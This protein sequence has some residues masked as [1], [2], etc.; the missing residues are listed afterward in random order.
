MKECVRSWSAVAW[1]LFA[2]PFIFLIHNPHVGTLIN[3]LVFEGNSCS[4]LLCVFVWI[5]N[6]VGN[7][8]HED[9][10]GGRELF[11]FQCLRSANRVQSIIVSLL[12]QFYSLSNVVLRFL[13]WFVFSNLH[14][15]IFSFLYLHS[16]SYISHSK[17]H[18]LTLLHLSCI[19]FLVS[20]YH[21]YF[22]FLN[23]FLTFLYLILWRKSHDSRIGNYFCYPFCRFRKL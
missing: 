23:F 3:K 4:V 13:Q 1:H 22:L 19:S 20:F 14:F 7:D 9:N 11:L 17:I 18:G 15:L 21:W 6:R 12:S 16:H 5:L 8:N 2:F 10:V